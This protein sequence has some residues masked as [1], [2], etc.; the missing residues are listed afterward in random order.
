MIL[1]EG[2]LI[3]FLYALV[4]GGTIVVGLNLSITRG[5]ARAAPF[6]FGVLVVDVIY[7]LLAVFAAGAASRYFVGSM[8]MHQGIYMGVQLFLIAALIGYGTY[9]VLQRRPDIVAAPDPA[10]ATI[11]K[12][13]TG[14]VLGPFSL[15]FTVKAATIVS[16][17]F[18][19]GFALLTSQAESL[20]L[21]QWSSISC[22]LF[23]SGF[24][25]GNFIYL[26]ACMRIASRYT[27]RLKSR[28][29]M[30]VQRI[31]GAAFVLLGSVLGLQVMFASIP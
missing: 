11:K 8:E 16:P 18:L 20:G 7:A 14:K 23:A 1:F 15:G 3:G 9:L 10:A 6:T 22:L 2:I 30:R 12:E 4:P 5:F 17:C 27:R 13:G 25:L 29:F 26:Q 24:A 19:V 28:Y 31:T 21:L